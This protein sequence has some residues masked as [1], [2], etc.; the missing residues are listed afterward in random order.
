MTVNDRLKQNQPPGSKGHSLSIVV[1][2]YNEEA[3]IEH[4]IE[5][6]MT[7]VPRWGVEDFEL[8]AV[9][10]GSQDNTHS[11]LE[12][13]AAKHDQV[14]L[15]N[16]EVNLGFGGTVRHGFEKATKDYVMVC[17]AD[18]RLTLEDVD[19]YLLLIQYADIVIG[20]RRH[21][22]LSL[23][24]YN[25]LISSVYHLLI[26]SLFRLNFFDVNWIHMYRRDQVASFIGKSDGVFL[27]AENL[28]RANRLGLRIVGVDVNFTDRTEG[29]A[30]G[31]QPRTIFRTINEQLAFFFRGEHRRAKKAKGPSDG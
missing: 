4:T 14:V 1:P 31:V 8:I 10:D 16:N 19:V 22:R 2:A 7:S 15:A 9:N 11:I 24:F 3:L 17:P 26:N 5:H 12:R 21:R 18:Y 25:R 20:Y 28:I 29:T 23:P 13:L 27:L 30:T 6:L